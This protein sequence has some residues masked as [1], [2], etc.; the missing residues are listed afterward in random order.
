M[1]L[2]NMAL[3]NMALSNAMIPPD[4]EQLVS[5]IAFRDPVAA[6]V[7]LTELAGDAGDTLALMHLLDPLRS[8]LEQAADPDAGLNHFA[9]FVHV[10]GVRWQ[11]YRLLADHPAALDTLIR[12]I[13][14]SNYLADILVRNPEYFDFVSNRLLL[15]ART[16]AEVS[17]ELSATCS[18][19]R[20]QYT[21]LDAIRRFRR[22]EMLR[23]G[24]ADLT[25]RFGLKE[26]TDQLSI[27][28]DA[29][30]SQ[31]LRTIQGGDTLGMFVLALGKLGGHELNYSSDID[32]VYASPSDQVPAA[33]KQAM[34]L[35]RV[36]GDMTSEGFLYRV[37]LRLRPYGTAGSLVVSTQ[38]LTS[39]LA[40]KAHP[41]ERQAMLKARAIAGDLNTAAQFLDGISTILH[42]DAPEIRVHVRDLKDRIEHEQLGARPACENVKIG[43][44]GI[45]DSEFIVQSL[46]LENLG[47]H[48]QLRSG[49][50]LLA[51]EQLGKLQILAPQDVEDLRV[52][53]E[54]LRT[55]E[56]RL[57]LMDNLQI[58][59]VPTDPHLKTVLARNVGCT[60][61]DPIAD[62][63]EQ[64][65]AAKSKIRTL[66]EIILPAS[67]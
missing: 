46:Q 37:D 33:T 5:A 13:S 47:D 51:L 3:P 7:R 25:G 42:Q 4:L 14:S 45:R 8:A 60:G 21:R 57:Q 19:F 12:V 52:A 43:R 64:L 28:A 1:A 62:L 40:D 11:L 63:N 39:Y 29:V 30:V 41:V 16:L 26:V 2:P 53:Y 23:I 20:S 18:V 65:V 54:F 56:H 32:L 44:G 17:A 59:A 66:F 50:T 58:H 35:T 55:V 34:Q 10:Y 49:N 36:L 48:E 9:R 27:L 24:V 22:R 38:M 6:S 67:G 31:C 61:E 15:Q